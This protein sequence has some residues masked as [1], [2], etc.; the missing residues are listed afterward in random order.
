MATEVADAQWADVLKLTGHEF[1]TPVT[2]ILGYLKMLLKE[3]AGPVNERQRFMLQEIEKSSA[4]LT[5]LLAE[6]SQ[7]SAL[8]SGKAT[9][10]RGDF[11]LRDVLTRS[12][13]ALPV[14]DREV[15]VELR[16][17]RGAARVSGD[18]ARLE[19]ALTSVIHGIRREI[20]TSD[21]LLVHEDVRPLGGRNVS[22]IAIGDETQVGE[23][24]NAD[25]SLLTAFNDA[26]GGCGLSLVIARR[27]INA[28]GASI[29]SPQKD[30][31]TDEQQAAEGPKA[32]KTKTGAV[33]A[34]PVS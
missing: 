32:D 8:E 27:I 13:A 5:V 20:V 33:I 26:R 3:Q 16:T 31:R 18:A 1:R 14:P 6:V 22:W 30:E 21:S 29:W 12:I 4:R 23:L 17:G 10:N 2:V 25:P 19:A 34:I 7:L 11:E 15:K 9:L 28:H 24:S